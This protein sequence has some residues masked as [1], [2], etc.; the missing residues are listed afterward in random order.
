VLYDI[1]PGDIKMKHYS[2]T[3]KPDEK[4][5]SVHAGCNLVEAAGLA[6]IVLNTV[7]G[8]KG[9]CGRC[10]V[11]LEPQHQAVLACQYRIESDITVFIPRSSRFAEH[12][13]LTE[14]PARNGTITPDV[15]KKYAA[16]VS[17]RA[18]LGLA[19]DI[20][21][22]TVVVKLV[23]MKTGD[24]LTT[25]ARLNPQAKFGDDV[26][27]RIA[28]APTGEKLCEL[29]KLI[30]D[31]IN[32]LIAECCEGAN[33]GPA[34]IYETCVVGNTT[35]NHIFLRLPISQ[36]GQAP[37]KAYSLD[38]RDLSPAEIGLKINPRGNVHCVANIAGF[39]G[40]DTTA[41]ALAAELD[42]AEEMTLAID[43]GTNGEVVLGTTNKLYAASCAAG[44]AFEGARITCGSHAVV[45]AIE[46]VILVGDKIELDVIG[47][48]R[49]RSICGSGLIDTV[50]VL[51]DMGV[52][53]SSGRFTNHN[54]IGKVGGAPAFILSHDEKGEPC[55]YLTQ[56]DIREVQLAKAA[57]STGI[58]L[59]EKR[60]SIIDTDIKNV[61]LAGAFGNYI[62]PQS[63]MRIGM[64]PNVPIE[65][66]RSIGN[67]ASSGAQLILLSRDYRD[68]AAK[69][70][71]KIQYIEIAQDPQFESVFTDSILFPA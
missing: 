16:E 48:G 36:L 40:A 8:R 45:G 7:C 24:V 46:A 62:R 27:S 65:I 32:G 67:A 2:V 68:L 23:D 10:S 43:I 52:I 1:P 55:V 41:V 71:K 28:Y 12:K 3:F 22:T 60:L 38:A 5:V 54:A 51:L 19:I 70:A 14:G 47:G 57:I 39:V 56:K 25:A 69:L 33:A 17:G 11:F 20:G 21:T 34:E 42:A 37:Y 18:I 35:M 63:A 26:I 30:V 44:P 6:G 59:L 50:A 61:F 66:I 29:N 53:D 9:V 64:L 4:K 49:P 13:I 58:K 15:Y 31:S